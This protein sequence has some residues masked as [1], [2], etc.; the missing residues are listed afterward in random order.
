MLYFMHKFKLTSLLLSADSKRPAGG[1]FGGFILRHVSLVVLFASFILLCGSTHFVMAAFPSQAMLL[2]VLKMLTA[3]VSVLT[4]IAMQIWMPQF[5][6]WWYVGPH[7]HVSRSHRPHATPSTPCLPR[8][9]RSCMLHP[10][11]LGRSLRAPPAGRPL[12]R[13]R[14]ASAPARHGITRTCCTY[15]PTSLLYIGHPSK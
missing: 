12:P 7:V 1:G 3:T 10:L 5:L 11:A 15:L 13:L 4:A 8:P 2:A 14:P 9:I 6:D